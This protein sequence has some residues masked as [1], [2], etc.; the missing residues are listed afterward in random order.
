MTFPTLPA[1]STLTPVPRDL[2]LSTY[3]EDGQPSGSHH[4]VALAS[5][6]TEGGVLI[7]PLVLTRGGRLARGDEVADPERTRWSTPDQMA[8]ARLKAATNEA[9]AQ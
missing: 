8:P 4:V 6:P 5:I 9:V 2:G 1:G 7:V 3:R